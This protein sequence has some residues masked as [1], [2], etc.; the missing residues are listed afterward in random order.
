MKNI[1]R[2]STTVAAFALA[3]GVFTSGLTPD[4]QSVT[5]SQSAQ[6]QTACDTQ[7]RSVRFTGKTSGSQTRKPNV[8]TNLRSGTTTSAQ[9][10]IAIPPNTRLT[11]SGWAYGSPVRD[12]WT[13]NQDYRWFRVTYRGK[14][15]WVASGVIYGNPPNAPLAP[16]CAPVSNGVRLPWRNGVT[17]TVSQTLHRDGYGLSALDIAIPAGTPVLAPADVTVAHSCLARGTNSHRAIKL[18]DSAG[19]FYSLIHVSASS[20]AVRVGTSYRKGQQIG[21]VAA[22]KPNDRNCAISYGVHLH[23]GL[24]SNPST[25]GGYSLGS[26]TRLNTRLT[27]R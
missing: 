4:G 10:L 12:L 11:F 6:A 19:R 16:N 18:R 5:F 7:V 3:C 25:M 9:I 17:G 13:G 27:A 22:D 20:S 2:I 1:H 21:V 8:N 26:S 24:P 14:T 23:M 15:G